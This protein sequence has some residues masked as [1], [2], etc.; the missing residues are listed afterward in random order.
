MRLH[1]CD[2]EYLYDYSGDEEKKAARQK[3]VDDRMEFLRSLGIRLDDVRPDYPTGVLLTDDQLVAAMVAG[4]EVK[5]KHSR[6]FGRMP[7]EDLAGLLEKFE[8]VTE[9]LRMVAP[10]DLTYNQRCEVHMP[11]QA[12]ATYNEVML[13]ENSCSD[14]LQTHL[15]SGWRIIAACPQPDAR[16]PDYILGRFN[17]KRDPDFRAQRG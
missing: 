6:E 15:D 12:L 16:R 4:Y 2:F 9:K 7:G 14:D 3:A 13:A 17:P 11:G 10:P 5:V 1:D 8:A